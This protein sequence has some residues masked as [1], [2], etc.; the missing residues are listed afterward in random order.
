MMKLAP[1]HAPQIEG[2]APMPCTTL[3]PIAILGGGPI[4]LVCA[5]MLARAGIACELVDARPLEELQRD[6]RLLALSRGSLLVLETL[7]GPDFAPMAAIERVHV[8]SQGDAGAAEL[9]AQDFPGANV[10]ATI[11]YADLVTALA[12]AAQSPAPSHGLI[13]IQRPRRALRIDQLDDRV[14]IALD[15]QSVLEA[16]LAVDAEGT[17]ARAPQAK[18]FAL[19]ADIELPAVRPGEAIERFTRAGPLALLPLPPAPARPRDNAGARS[20]GAPTARA[21]M[22]MI[23]CQ[24]AALAQARL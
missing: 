11:W 7:L 22:S 12:A 14:R 21:R 16:R 13:R 2:Q 19:L 1:R 10:G 4:G 24:P 6:R 9:G 18:N 23:W 17:P 5:L 20:S 8:S 15:D 3:V